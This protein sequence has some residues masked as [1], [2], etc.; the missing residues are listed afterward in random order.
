MKIMSR[1]GLV[2]FLWGL[3]ACSGLQWQPKPK[4]QIYEEFYDAVQQDVRRKCASKINFPEKCKNIKTS[5]FD[6]YN[7]QL[8]E[9]SDGKPIKHK[10]TQSG[11][12]T[13]KS[14]KPE[15]SKSEKY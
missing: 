15:D 6:E 7:R 9:L 4:Q 12:S 8:R 11:T 2:V 5:S 13:L 14:T 1:L 3:S 10:I